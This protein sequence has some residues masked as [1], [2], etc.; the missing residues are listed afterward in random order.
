MRRNVLVALLALAALAAALPAAA[1]AQSRAR[2]DTQ[3]LARIPAPGYPASA[4][5]HPNG[6]VY[7][8]TYANPSG[9]ALPSRVFEFDPDTRKAL[10]SWV[11]PDQDLA[12][13]HGTGFSVRSHPDE[14]ESKTLDYLRSAVTLLQTKAPD[15]LDDYRVLVMDVAESVAAAAK[16][17]EQA[18]AA[19]VEKI[20]QAVGGRPD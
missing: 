10:R 20:R 16:G 1:G 6:R 13:E 17:G 7:V 4:Y 18:E 9:D 15:D 3:L 2:F 14:I 11:V 19:E 12:A 5:P 8:G